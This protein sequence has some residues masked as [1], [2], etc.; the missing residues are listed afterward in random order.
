[1]LVGGLSR[2][3]L[4]KVGCHVVIV[5]SVLLQSG[6]GGGP[7]LGKVPLY[8]RECHSQGGRR[9]MAVRSECRHFG[10][11]CRVMMWCRVMVAVCEWRPSLNGRWCLH[12]GVVVL[13]GL[14]RPSI[15]PVGSRRRGGRDSIVVNLALRSCY[16]VVGVVRVEG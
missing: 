16:G 14:F 1:M 10:S 15:G 5:S 13:C 8:H 2:E 7:S 3:L 11:F 12:C 4:L 6:G 9:L